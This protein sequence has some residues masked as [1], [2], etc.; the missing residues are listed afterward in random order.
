MGLARA[1]RSQG[2]EVRVL[3]P[4]DGAPPDV[5]V[6]PLGD[7][8]PLATN[9]SVAP[10]APDLPCALRIVG[11][12]KVAAL[13]S[14]LSSIVERH[15]IL[16][17]TIRAIDGRPLQLIHP[18]QR[19]SLPLIDLQEYPS[20]QRNAH[21][22]QLV[23]REGQRPFN[24]EEGPLFRCVLFRLTEREHVFLMVQHHVISDGWSLGVFFKE[25]EQLYHALANDLPSA[26]PPLP[27]QYGDFALWQQQQTQDQAFDEHVQFWKEKLAG[28][29]LTLDLPIDRARPAQPGQSM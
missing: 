9:G 23:R 13:E 21:L 25:L 26:L 7:S 22:E 12:L 4:C 20:H 10:I 18:P 15:E 27:I 11:Q 5:G 1:L 16:R 3:A 2:H 24:L 14:A 6:T 28:A 19:A 8:V 29:P 17:T